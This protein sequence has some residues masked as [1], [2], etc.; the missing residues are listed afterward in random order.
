MLTCPWYKL[1][2]HTSPLA[3][4]GK[5]YGFRINLQ[6]YHFIVVTGCEHPWLFVPVWGQTQHT[7]VTVRR[8]AV[9]LRKA[10][11]RDRHTPYMPPLCHGLSCCPCTRP[12]P[13]LSLPRPAPFFLGFH[14][15][16][17]PMD[18]DDTGLIDLLEWRVH[19]VG[20]FSERLSCLEIASVSL[21][22]RNESQWEENTALI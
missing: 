13:C 2:T 11:T 1:E 7:H 6:S 20:V 14:M 5:K 3:F 16:C 22:G 9:G 4:L 21:V 17:P 12:P 15:S 8:P 10:C 18:N 19:L